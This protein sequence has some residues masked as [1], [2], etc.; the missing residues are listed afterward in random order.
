MPFVAFS[1]PVQLLA[2]APDAVVKVGILALIVEEKLSLFHRD[3][4]CYEVLLFTCFCLVL[5]AT[6]TVYG[7]YSASP[8]AAPDP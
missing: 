4:V 5:M 7:V 1:C 3:D 2:A 8:A 6:P